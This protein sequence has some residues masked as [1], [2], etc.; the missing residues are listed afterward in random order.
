MAEQSRVKKGKYSRNVKILPVTL[1]AA[2]EPEVEIWMNSEG[3][4]VVRQKTPEFMIYIYI[5]RYRKWY[6]TETR[7]SSFDLNECIYEKF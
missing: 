4:R 1:P 6:T 5:L 3:F 2:W 7:T